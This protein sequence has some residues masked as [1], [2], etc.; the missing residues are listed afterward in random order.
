MSFLI[1][2]IDLAF[3]GLAVGFTSAIV[4]DLLGIY[5]F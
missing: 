1:R 2:I 5:P 3:L 4:T